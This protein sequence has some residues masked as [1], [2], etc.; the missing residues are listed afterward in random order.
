MSGVGAQ[1]APTEAV[2]PLTGNPVPEASISNLQALPMNA[3]AASTVILEK[4]YDQLRERVNA[5]LADNP[6]AEISLNLSGFSR[7]GAQAVAFA[8]LLNERGIGPFKPGEVRIANLLLLDP[9]DQTNGALDTGPPTNVDNTLVMVATGEARDIM[10]AM[11][12]GADARV[13]AV[14]VSHSGLGGSYNSQG[15]AAITLQKAKEFL[16]AGGSPVAD[17]PDHLKPDWEQMFI[18]NSGVNANGAL[19][20]GASPTWETDEPNRRYEGSS[21]SDPSVQ[22]AIGKLPTYTSIPTQTMARLLTQRPTPT[23]KSSPN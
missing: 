19:K 16:E 6:N 2:H 4:A 23:V 14:P 21:S 12:V 10:P 3:G 1:T 8:N 11:V 17:I 13:I 5:V 7:G 20:F 15:T 18:H 22:A 9:V